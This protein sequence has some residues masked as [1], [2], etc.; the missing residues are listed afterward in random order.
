VVVITADR[1]Q[2]VV[3]N[4]F[5]TSDDGHLWTL[6]GGSVNDFDITSVTQAFITQASVSVSRFAWLGDVDVVNSDSYLTSAMF[7]TVAGASIRAD[8]LARFVDT[9]NW[10]GFGLQYEVAAA[11]ITA[12]IIKRV[13][14]VNTSLGSATVPGS[15]GYTVGQSWTCRAYCFGSTL[16]LKAWRAD[17]AEPAG[18]LLEFT[19]S[20][21]TA[22][23]SPGIRTFSNAGNT[24]T[25]AL[26]G[27]TG[28]AFPAYP[29]GLY[30]TKHF[31]G[32]DEGLFGT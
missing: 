8:L 22:A 20:D 14:G 27:F 5:G 10:Y 11:S 7:D 3:A 32:F 4:S 25:N 12:S 21:L 16:K 17:Q 26:L 19:D 1:W 29:G 23:G 13:G 24:N 30:V 2:R 28:F 6:A 9:N 15:A 18:W 31:H